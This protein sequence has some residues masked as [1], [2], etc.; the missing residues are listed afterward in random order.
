MKYNTI[1]F[2]LGFTLVTFENFSLKRYFKTLN[3]GLEQM[4]KFLIKEKILK[5]P[6]IFKKKFKKI[7]NRNFQQSLTKYKEITTE[8]TLI[9]TLSSLDLPKLDPIIM[10]KAILIYHSTE[11]AFWKIRATAKPL[12]QKLHAENFKLGVLSNAPY[13]EGI[14]SFLKI[15]NIEQYFYAITTS[16]QIGFTKPD[17]RTF[18][19]VLHKLQSMPENTIMIGDDLKNDIYGAQQLGMKT[20]LIKKEFDFPTEHSLNAIP[21]RKITDLPEVLPIIHEWN[22]T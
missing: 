12:L 3:Q 19:Y 9:Q 22:K 1:I 6:E 10:H 20:I 17:R 7:R 18:E 5:N 15:N 13:H 11:G 8:Q 4:V 14:L 16:A 21:D 2:D